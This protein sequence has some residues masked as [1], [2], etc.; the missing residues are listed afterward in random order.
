VAKRRAIGCIFGVWLA[1]AAPPA[2]ADGS[3]LEGSGKATGLIA[4]PA[5]PPDFVKA[6]RPKA[7]P[8]AIP[9]FA[10]PQEP[11]SKVKSP[12]ELKAMDADLE[13]ASRRVGGGDDGV[14]SGR[15]AR[16]AK[17]MPA[18]RP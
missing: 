7:E 8:S 16:K 12:A 18:A 4:P 9:V 11:R 5:D 6:S 3:L 15:A 13:H 1:L 10:T 14:G 17:R 2:W